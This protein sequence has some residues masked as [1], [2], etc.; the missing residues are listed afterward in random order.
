MMYGDS[1]LGD[2]SRLKCP[3]TVVFFTVKEHLIFV[4]ICSSVVYV[5]GGVP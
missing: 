4:T 2:R 5:I 1:S 3:L